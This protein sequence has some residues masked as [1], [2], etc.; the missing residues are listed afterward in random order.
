M[1]IDDRSRR[2][3][4]SID[5]NRSIDRYHT[6]IPPN[7]FLPTNLEVAQRQR[8]VDLL[9]QQQQLRDRLLREL[10]HAAQVLRAPL[11]QL[12]AVAAVWPYL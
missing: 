5:I 10:A 11:A 9:P 2:D 3:R 1:S 6:F 4:S 8:D 12:V 7:V